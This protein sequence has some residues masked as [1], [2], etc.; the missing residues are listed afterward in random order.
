MEISNICMSEA[1]LCLVS[2]LNYISRTITSLIILSLFLGSL[3]VIGGQNPGTGN[4]MNALPVS[5]TSPPPPTPM[6]PQPGQAPVPEAQAHLEPHFDMSTPRNVTALVGKN[7]Y[8]SCRVR[9]LGN[10]SVSPERNLIYA[11]RGQCLLIIYASPV[12]S[13]VKS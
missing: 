13:N 2:Y 9:N 3:L 6:P 11:S 8:L 1:D 7:A 12:T 5:A 10:K 4:S